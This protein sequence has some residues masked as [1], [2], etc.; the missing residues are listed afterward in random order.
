MYLLPFYFKTT[1]QEA[2][3]MSKKMT[4]AILGLGSRGLQ[5]YGEN[6]QK[7]TALLWK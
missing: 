5:V 7:T 6:R 2:N 4:V 3:F 1:S